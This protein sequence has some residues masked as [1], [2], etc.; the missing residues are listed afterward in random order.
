MQTARRRRT[1]WAIAASALAHVAV[2]IVAL[3][4]RPTLPLPAD[5]AGPPE[6]IIPI[7]LLPRTPP[8]LAAA[9]ARQPSAVRLHR[10][11]LR[12]DESALPVAPL[13]APTA[14]IRPA[15]P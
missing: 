9:G 13:P 8:P 2:L 15:E 14:P 12:Q 4:Q 11:A 6:P 10:R 1:T 3:L 7:L 5:E